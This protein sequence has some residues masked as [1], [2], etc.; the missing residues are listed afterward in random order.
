MP[1][2]E[3]T[4]V[5]F[6]HQL[7]SYARKLI[8]FFYAAALGHLAHALPIWRVQARCRPQR[9]SQSIGGESTLFWSVCCGVIEKG[10]C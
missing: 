3:P 6:Q 1:G 10:A 4:N 7:G 8:A 2:Q 9:S 5:D